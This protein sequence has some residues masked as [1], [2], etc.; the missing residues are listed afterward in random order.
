MNE[1]SLHLQ[2]RRNRSRTAADILSAMGHET[3]YD[4]FFKDRF[5]EEIKEREVF[6]VE[7]LTWADKIIVFEEH[8]E[9]LLKKHGYSFWGKSYNLDIEDMYHYNQKS[10]I[11]IV[12]E[13]LKH[14]E[15][16]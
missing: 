4:G 3:R 2:S 16:L 11:M 12:K 13:K 15:F 5:N 9:E 6:C 1:N 14:Y 8:H 7:N 10:L